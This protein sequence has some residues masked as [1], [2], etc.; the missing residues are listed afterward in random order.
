MKLYI[1]TI[2]FIL[3]LATSTSAQEGSMGLTANLLLPQSDFKET[4]DAIG[5]GISFYGGYQLK[6]SPIY[7]G[8]EIGFANFSN[9][10]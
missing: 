9:K 1:L 7:L 2:A 8:A 6:N 3:S 4:I 5:G 10:I